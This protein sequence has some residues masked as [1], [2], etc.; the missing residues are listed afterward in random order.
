MEQ[1]SHKIEAWNIGLHDISDQQIEYGLTKYLEEQCAV[2]G[3][4]DWI[5]TVGTFRQYCLTAKGHTNFEDEARDAWT[6]ALQTIKG[7]GKASSVYFRNPLIAE[8]IR[9]MGGWGN[10][11]HW[12]EK[13]LDFKKND[14]I[15]IYSSL[16]KRGGDYNH[17]LEGKVDREN[18]Q[19][20]L[21]GKAE[22]LI[23]FVGD[24]R[25][26]EKNTLI[27]NLNKQ[28]MNESNILKSFQQNTNL[29]VISGLLDS[30]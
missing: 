4:A 21:S 17:L 5:P 13:A 15:K 24:F 11:A 3:K 8:T 27:V 23:T 2:K 16:R 7:I 18:K 10:S 30:K 20:I 19:Y 9:Q 1:L 6:V 28:L 29:K 26:E 14:F 12:E 25:T 22:R